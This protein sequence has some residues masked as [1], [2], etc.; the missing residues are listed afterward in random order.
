MKALRSQIR[1]PRQILCSNT[2]VFNIERGGLIRP[3]VLATPEIFELA[4]APLLMWEL[5]RR[6][7]GWR[8]G[9]GRRGKCW[10]DAPPPPLISTDELW[11]CEVAARDDASEKQEENNWCYET[12]LEN[13]L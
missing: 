9:G 5:T 12:N 1:E 6:R 3:V 2:L 7:E 8:N 4:G 13:V 11:T 10:F